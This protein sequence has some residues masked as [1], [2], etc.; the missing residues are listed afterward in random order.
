MKKVLVLG[1]NGFIGSWVIKNLMEK[2]YE[3]TSFD[4]EVHPM[5]C[6]VFVGD[7]KD[8]EAVLD[9]VGKHDGV[10]HLAGRLGTAETINNPIPS[11]ET[12]V[13]GSLNVFHA[14]REYK[15]PAVYIAVGNHWMNNSY[16]ISKTTAERFAFMYNKEHGTKI[17]VVRGL[18]A[19]GP[20]QKWHPVK[21]IVPTFIINALAGKPIPVYGDGSQVM[22]MIWAGDIAEIL[23][24]ALIV[25]H[26][27]YDKV[28]EA[29][30]G[31]DTTVNDIASIINSITENPAGI[32]YLPMRAGEPEKSIVLGDPKTLEPLGI[33]ASE[34]RDLRAGLEQTVE[35]YREFGPKG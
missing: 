2:G 24:R 10:I 1:G 3:V 21:K 27:V 12:N 34:L 32:D 19:Y 17:A 25:D 14:V 7:V 15:I 8:Q 18:N 6:N 13:I 30:T 35:W 4:R 9:A 28:F 29:G 33:V 5:P 23:V 20:N 26:G 16:S 11:V 22:D 31:R